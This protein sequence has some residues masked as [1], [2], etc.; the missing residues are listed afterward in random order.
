LPLNQAREIRPPVLVELN[1]GM[2]GGPVITPANRV[3]A[4]AVSIAP[5]SGGTRNRLPQGEA[6]IR[7]C[8]RDRYV[9]RD[10]AGVC[11]VGERGE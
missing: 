5:P 3:A 10:P 8:A 6:F 11:G 1:P 2:S 4:G 9:G 7:S